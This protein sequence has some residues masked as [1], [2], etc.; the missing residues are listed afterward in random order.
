MGEYIVRGRLFFKIQD[1]YYQ[2][3]SGVYN[4]TVTNGVYTEKGFIERTINMFTK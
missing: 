4:V 2:D 3:N 1:G